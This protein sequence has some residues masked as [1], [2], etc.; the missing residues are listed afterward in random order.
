M[1]IALV[2]GL[3]SGLFAARVTPANMQNV[4]AEADRVSKL[5]R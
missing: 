5:A 3:A 1:A 2:I 4:A